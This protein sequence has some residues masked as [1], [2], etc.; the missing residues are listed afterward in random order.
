MKNQLLKKKF[1]K[2]ILIHYLENICEN[3]EKY[4]LFNIE[5]YKRSELNAK[6]QI[7]LE[8]IRDYYHNSKQFYTDYPSNY[9]RICTI[10]RQLCN[11]NNIK[12][13]YKT[14]YSKSKH[15]IIYFIYKEN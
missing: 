11:V 1:D 8:N 5:A 13:T 4:Y 15:S 6:T 12:F 14:I 2:T 10:I 3:H 9:N 7:F